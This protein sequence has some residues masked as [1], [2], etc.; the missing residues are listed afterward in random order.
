MLHEHP[1]ELADIKAGMAGSQ[2]E[3]A[4]LR[5]RRT[6]YYPVAA[7]VAAGLLFTVYGFVSGEQTALKTIPPQAPT[8]EVYV[9]QTPTPLP[10]TPTAPPAPT[11]APTT[12]GG[13]TV[14]TW[15]SV[16]PIFSAK[17]AMCHGAAL[18]TNG[19]NLTTYA[20][21]MKGATD[22]PVIVPNDSA[23]S[24]LFQI[25]STGGHPGQLSAEELAILQAW[26]DAGALEK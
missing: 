26:I 14:T 12:T 21:T 17:C 5:Q 16:A 25:Q 6:L 11:A 8:I 4:V 22:G 9:P 24:K 1:L 10:P 2:P 18:A 13:S 20:D 15:A 19:L 23:G 7:V 3:P